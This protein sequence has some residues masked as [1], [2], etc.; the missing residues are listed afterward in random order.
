MPFDRQKR[1]WLLLVYGVY[2]RLMVDSNLSRQKEQ[3]CNII[4]KRRWG[5]LHRNSVAGC[6]PWTRMKSCIF[7]W[8]CKLK[9]RL[10]D[11]LQLH[12]TSSDSLQPH[13]TSSEESVFY[14]CDLRLVLVVFAHTTLLPDYFIVIIYLLI[15]LI[16][17][18]LLYCYINFL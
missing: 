11:N 16:K 3:Y 13:S 1:R 5:A 7:R 9:Y 14:F 2:R 15:L 6:L 10:E 17:N 18:Q 8:H 12:S 4:R